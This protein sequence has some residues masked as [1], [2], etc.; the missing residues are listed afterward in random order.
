[1]STYTALDRFNEAACN[2]LVKV[3]QDTFDGWKAVEVALNPRPELPRNC[4]W[5][6]DGLIDRRSALPDT[7]WVNRVGERGIAKYSFES[8]FPVLAWRI[9]HTTP[10]R[11]ENGGDK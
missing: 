11:R 10:E 6:E 3:N 9:E 1:M 8:R 5:H 4:R 7:M 2:G